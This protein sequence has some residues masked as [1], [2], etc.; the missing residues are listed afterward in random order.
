MAAEHE[1]APFVRILGKGRNGARSLQRSEARDAM[2]MICCYEVE[3][4]QLGAFLMLLRVKEETAEEIAGFV[5]ALRASLPI[6]PHLPAVAIDW[7]AYAGKKR[8]LPWFLLAALIL[9]RNGYPVMMHGLSR[10]DERVYMPEALA[11]LDMPV[12]QSIREAA[13]GI[14]QTGFAYLPIERL[15]RLVYDLMGN[16][17][18]YRINRYGNPISILEPEGT[19]TEMEWS[20]GIDAV[21]LLLISKYTRPGAKVTYQYDS[22]GSGVLFAW[23]ITRG[24]ER[25]IS[26]LWTIERQL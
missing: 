7:P 4:E 5:D 20:D 3:P 1:F 25:R 18:T 12:A 8:Q 24:T 15:S 9:A 23:E 19:L 2:T 14:E 10:D 17:T 21:D 22:Q 13:R 6:G 11:A 16:V 26:V